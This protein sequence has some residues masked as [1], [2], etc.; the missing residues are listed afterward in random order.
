MFVAKY[1][2]FLA[3]ILFKDGSYVF[4][5]GAKDLFKYLHDQKKYHPSRTSGGIVKIFVNDYYELKMI[6]GKDAVFVIG[7]DIYGP[8]GRELIPFARESDAREF[9]RDH[10]GKALLKFKEVTPETLKGMD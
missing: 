8:M 9:M 6:D 3:A 4:F 7:S 5:D 2:D 1:P 10:K